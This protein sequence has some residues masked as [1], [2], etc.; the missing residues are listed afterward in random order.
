MHRWLRACALATLLFLATPEKATTVEPPLRVVISANSGAAVAPGGTATFTASAFRAGPTVPATLTITLDPVW[1]ITHLSRGCTAHSTTVAVCP[2]QLAKLAPRSATVWAISR[3]IQPCM[4][5]SA[6][7]A[8]LAAPNTTTVR[9]D[10]E[11][12]GITNCYLA[13]TPLVRGYRAR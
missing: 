3:R 5:I 8:A 9:S 13:F 1:H 4:R 2:M 6:G 7:H 12:I 11:P 10:T